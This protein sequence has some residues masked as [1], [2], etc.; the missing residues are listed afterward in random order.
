MATAAG[1]HSCHC[2]FLLLLPTPIPGRLVWIWKSREQNMDLT[3][4]DTVGSF[5][6]Q[7]PHSIS[8]HACS[9]STSLKKTDTLGRSSACNMGGGI[10]FYPLGPFPIHYTPGNMKHECPLVSG[11]SF[12]RTPLVSGWGCIHQYLATVNWNYRY[13]RAPYLWRVL[14]A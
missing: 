10:I 4:W 7:I 11:A 1:R 13:W 6:A 12:W 14:W 9:F 3:K 5:F 8:S 2:E